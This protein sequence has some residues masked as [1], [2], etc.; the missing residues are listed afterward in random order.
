[1]HIQDSQA[2][3][4]DPRHF[5]KSWPSVLA[6]HAKHSA[7]QVLIEALRPRVRSLLLLRRNVTAP[8]Y[9]LLGRQLLRLR[10][11]S[12]R[13][14]FRHLFPI[15]LSGVLVHPDA[16]RLGLNLL[17]RLLQVASVDASIAGL[18]PSL[19]KKLGT[20]AGAPLGEASLSVGSRVCQLQAFCSS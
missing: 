12:L 7:S 10:R 14:S 18:L 17:H 19:K 1:M 2:I 9:R 20:H 8:T 5:T 6:K 15:R 3:Y 4:A 13:W 16:L 11:R